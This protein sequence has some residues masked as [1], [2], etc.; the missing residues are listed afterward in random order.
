M[1]APHLLS[2]GRLVRRAGL[3]LLIAAAA[4]A[5]LLPRPAPAQPAETKAAS[6]QLGAWLPSY[7]DAAQLYRQ[8]RATRIDRSHF[9]RF[10]YRGQPVGGTF[11]GASQIDG[12]TFII[13]GKNVN[14]GHV[15]YD[16]TNGL[17]FYTA[18]CCN[19]ST[20]FLGL[21]MPPPRRVAQ[22]SVAGVR[23]QRGLALGDTPAA[24][25]AADGP[26]PLQPV[27]GH[28]EL[29]MLTYAAMAGLATP[30]CA[31]L[32]LFVFKNDQLIALEFYNAC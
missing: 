22:A 15:V 10:L 12:G 30:T 17:A 2:P 5:A 14:K 20:A 18:S 23:T 3:T 8:K 27:P 26:A 29:R 19:W 1:T 32:Q 9:D 7:I 28:P 6:E 4:C 13:F 11:G 31:Q 21:A 16:Y 25:R 24:I